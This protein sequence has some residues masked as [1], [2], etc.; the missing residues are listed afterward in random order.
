[1][2]KYKNLIIGI[3][4]AVLL[5]AIIIGA[6]FLYS[7]F[8]DE[9]AGDNLSVLESKETSGDTK[10]TSKEIVNNSEPH[11][12]DEPDSEDYSAPDFTVT[13]ENGKEVKLSDFKGKPVVLNFWATWCYYCKEEMPDFDEAS[14]KHPEV[15]FMMVNA[16]D[17]VRETLEG[18]KKYVDDEGY[19]FDVFYDTKS[20]AVSTFYVTAFPTTYFISSEG[21]LIARGS[22]MLDADSLERG[23]EMITETK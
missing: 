2:A 7:K 23:I 3:A 20:E 6:S 17:G 13:N 5:I 11:N 16:T 1:M 19:S 15:Q 22:G 10:D 21:E 4:S 14:K 12:D 18:A 8:S 9:L